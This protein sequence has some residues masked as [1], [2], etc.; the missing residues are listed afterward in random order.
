[1]H[2][3]AALRLSWRV[4]PF[5]QEAA[6]NA[7]L[8]G[9][10][11]APLMWFLVL[12]RLSL[13]IDREQTYVAEQIR[14][15]EQLREAIDAHALV[16]ITDLQGCIVH[17]NSNLC[18]VSGYAKE[19]LLGQDHRILNSGYHDK[20][21]MRGLW[22]TL[23]R[24]NI[25]QGQFCNRRKDGRLY[26]QDSTI[27][28]LW[29]NDGKP[30]Q[31]LAICR[32]I[33]IQKLIEQQLGILKRAVDASGDM[34][35]ISDAKSRIQYANPAL[36]RFTGWTDAALIGRKSDILISVNADAA[37]L[38]DMQQTLT[39]GEIWSGRILGHRASIT[40]IYLEIDDQASPVDPLDFW[41]E[42][43]ITPVL[44]PGGIVSG[45]VQIQR[46]ISEQVAKEA[47]QKM[48]N[49][50]TAARLAIAEELQIDKP[51]KE[52]FTQVLEII[53]GLKAFDLQR[54]GGVFLRAAGENHLDMFVLHGNFSE[55]FVAKEQRI[56]DGDC[57]CGRAA[58]SG[59]VLI[60]DDCFCDPRHEHKF[61]GMQ[62]HG[63]YIVPIAAT[64]AVH[65]VLFLYTD[66]YPTHNENRIAMLKQVGEMM[67][68]AVLQDQAKSSLEAARDMAMQAALAKSEFLANMS[69]EIRNPMNGVLGMLDLLRE[70]DMTRSQWDLA[71]TAYSSAEALLGILNDILDFSRLEAGKIEIEQ[72]DFDFAALVEDVCTLYAGRAFAKGLELNCSLPEALPPRWQGDPTRI[73]QVLN[74]LLGNAVKFTGH[75]EVSVAVTASTHDT[76]GTGLI[77]IEVRDTGVGIAPG[78]QARLFQPFSQADTSTVRLFGGTG[79]G[80]SISKDLVELM[81]GN[82]GVKSALDQGACF[83][84]TLPLMPSSNAEKVPARSDLAGKRI[85]IVDDNATNRE[86]LQRYLTHWAIDVTQASNARTALALLDAAIANGAP[87]DVVLL[88]QQMP[89]MDGLSLARVISENP[90]ISAAPRILLSSGMLLGDSERQALGITQSLLK[91]VR[92][93]QLF[94]AL[95]NALHVP[96]LPMA[97]KQKRPVG[98]PIYNGKTVLVVEDNTV[99][100]KVILAKL[101]KYGLKIDIASNGQIALQN[102][103]EN[104]YDLVLMDCQMPVMDGYEATREFRSK[105]KEKG[106]PR[107][108]IVALTAHAIAGE[109]EKCLAAGMDDF[110]TKPVTWDSLS[111]ILAQWLGEKMHSTESSDAGYDGRTEQN[112]ETASGQLW[113]RAG[114]LK[115]M[116]GD[117]DLLV[118][119]I[120]VFLEEM[121]EQINRLRN[122][123]AQS[124]LAALADAAHAIKGLAGHFC[125]DTAKE[126]AA[127][128]EQTARKG[129]QADYPRM[130]ETLAS[131]VQQLMADM[132]QTNNGPPQ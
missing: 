45:Y 125:A 79:L 118:E 35:L 40:S 131:A 7:G 68:L 127:S 104:A 81:G 46:D 42:M 33:T 48:E 103:A 4:L 37:A 66:P 63:H 1:M 39:R 52:R 93:V 100:Q 56:A 90:A 38:A 122:A 58:V 43:S 120:G 30:R 87:Y 47:L 111:D 5:F 11:A 91:P 75:G 10:V 117:E 61:T 121:P 83:W 71:E 54:K 50:D 34:I 86:I 29:G 28:P 94:D 20:V 132:R 36:C 78:V 76:A 73:R 55:E 59:E 95:A 112:P 92:Q 129:I 2:L 18:T 32:D 70:T 101:A 130:T 108:P 57:L 31:Y 128:L 119:M 85:L 67:A 106:A 77:R 114:A 123:Q 74:N 107:L 23:A 96:T 62:A 102:L 22:R 12:R 6:L 98:Q 72:V 44:N 109:R 25:W 53:F 24:G 27:V 89:E 64:A 15:N 17:V 88:D 14:L 110:L 84:F 116:D 65:G 41:T 3:I 26:W 19:E 8:L 124:D 21:Y 82:I 99:N 80:L 16:S 13:Q 69:H 9:L 51:L 60:S 49:N 97:A 115:I 113:D 105:E 126:C